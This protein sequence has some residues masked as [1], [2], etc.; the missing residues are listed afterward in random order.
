MKRGRFGRARPLAIVILA[1]AFGLCPGPVTVPARAGQA[2]VARP[3]PGDL[4]VEAIERIIRDYLLRNP[5]LLR[6]ALQVLEQRQ[7]EAEAARAKQ[8]ILRHREE[9]LRD[10]DSPVGGNPD[11]DATVVEFFDYRCPYCRTFARTLADVERED[12]QL[13]VVYKEFPILGPGSVLAAK[14][15][16]AAREQGKYFPL[17]R[18]LMQAGGEF[19][20]ARILD[21]AASVGLDAERLRKDMQAPRV[22]AALRRNH[23]LARALGINGTPAFVI[24]DELVVGVMEAATLKAWIAKARSR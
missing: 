4:P 3:A 9:I 6:D 11:G 17:H 14:A 19:S 18:A 23:A 22:E 16:L 21:I 15:A 5:E 20:E 7:R 1:T 10:P 2:P 24:G 8:A 12:S 13:R